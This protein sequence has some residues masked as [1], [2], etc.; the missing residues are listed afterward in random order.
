MRD[1]V[2]ASR[3]AVTAGPWATLAAFLAV[4]LPAGQDW[5]TRMARGEV[6][7]AD[8]RPAAAQEPCVSGQ[9][10]WYWRCPPP[11]TPVPF[12]IRVLAQDEHLVVVDKPHFLAVMPRGRHLHET[13]LVRLKKLLGLST[14]VP[15]HRLD[16]ETAGVLVLLVQPDTRDAYQS[17][18]RTGQVHKVY[19]AVAPWQPDMAGPWEYRSRLEAQ[20]GARFMQMQTVPGPP[21]AHTRIELLRRL[22]GAAGLAHYRLQPLTGRKHQLRA[23]LCALG[24]PI[25]GDRIY[26]ELWPESPPGTAEDWSHP[27][28]LLAREVS[29]TDPITGVQRCFSSGHTLAAVAQ[30]G[31]L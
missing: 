20:T 4:R 18:L 26:P 6:L 29:F 16:R 5:P 10:L 28:Q 23:Q 2:S 19:E 30:A 31:G 1:G 22:P 8:G 12:E 24:M 14:L 15:M 3:V 27:L 17:L 9:V 25:V 13:V 21:N 11:E 7:H